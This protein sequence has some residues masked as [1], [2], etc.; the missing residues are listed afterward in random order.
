MKR[1]VRLDIS[2]EATPLALARGPVTPNPRMPR[3]GW[4]RVSWDKFGLMQ[5]RNIKAWVLPNQCN[6]ISYGGPN[7]IYIPLQDSKTM[8]NTTNTPSAAYRG[9]LR[10]I[11]CI[12]S[13]VFYAQGT[14]PVLTPLPYVKSPR[15]QD[16]APKLF[17]VLVPTALADQGNGDGANP[18]V[19][20]RA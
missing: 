17:V 9:N 11:D 4:G 5:E 7:A 15:S 8:S 12:S 2:Q 20:G 6:N 3:K 14:L 13:L 16:Q 18:Q 10:V 19:A 1:D